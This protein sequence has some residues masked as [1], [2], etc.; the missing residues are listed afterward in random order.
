MAVV[1]KKAESVRGSEDPEMSTAGQKRVPKETYEPPP[2]LRSILTY[3]SYLMLYVLGIVADFLR[4]VGL[5]ETLHVQVNKKEV[6]G[7]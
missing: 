5:K 2:L 3:I 1:E 7:Y 4:S 6:K